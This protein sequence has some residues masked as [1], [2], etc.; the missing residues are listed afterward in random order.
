VWVHG[1]NYVRLAGQEDGET[2]WGSKLAAGSNK[3]LLKAQEK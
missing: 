1:E 2:T 3:M